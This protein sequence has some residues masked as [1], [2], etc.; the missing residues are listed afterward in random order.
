VRD[1]ICSMRGTSRRQDSSLWVS[2]ATF[3]L[4]ASSGEDSVL[5]ISAAIKPILLV[6]VW[7]SSSIVKTFGRYDWQ[8]IYQCQCDSEHAN[9][10]D[11]P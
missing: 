3:S 7:I 8:A 1:G 5:E 6:C 2:M 10:L 11:L 4:V 9:K